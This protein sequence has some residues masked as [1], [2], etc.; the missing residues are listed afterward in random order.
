VTRSTAIDNRVAEAILDAAADLLARDGEPPSL[1]DV[2]AAAGVARA[3]LYRHFPTRERL[4]QALSAAA[5][6]AIAARLAEADL[7]AVPVSEA[8][9]RVARVIASGGSKYAAVA[10]RFGTSDYAGDAEQQIGVMIKSLLRRG[11]DDG[12]LRVDL[13]VDELT[14]TL[15]SLLRAAAR[16]TADHQA[17]A[18]KAAALV[19]SVFLHGTR[20]PAGPDPAQQ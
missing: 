4:L 2:A 20:N 8:I 1:T 5:R 10:G 17:G 11:I 13:T 15:G 7:D 14:V 16:M 6:D 9:A 18:E 19:T 3:T 12:T